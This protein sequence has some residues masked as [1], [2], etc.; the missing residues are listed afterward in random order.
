M[1]SEIIRRHRMHKSVSFVYACW[2]W[3]VA[4]WTWW[5]TN[6]WR[7][8]GRTV[9]KSWVITHWNRSSWGWHDNVIIIYVI[10]CI[11][12]DLLGNLWMCRSA[13]ARRSISCH[14]KTVAAITCWLTCWESKVSN[15]FK[16]EKKN[17]FKLCCSKIHFRIAESNFGCSFLLWKFENFIHAEKKF[18]AYKTHSAL[19]Y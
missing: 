18:L 17:F 8:V 2:W 14:W 7:I 5:W 4:F 1:T 11:V 10:I 19:K 6:W 12:S 15:Y 9:A 3:R 13:I 16:K